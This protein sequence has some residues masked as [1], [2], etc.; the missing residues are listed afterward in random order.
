MGRPVFS[1]RGGSDSILIVA[2]SETT[3]GETLIPT[4]AW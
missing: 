1:T 3:L 4:G 2:T